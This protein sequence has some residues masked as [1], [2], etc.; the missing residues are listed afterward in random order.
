MKKTRHT[1][2]QIIEKLRQ[3][4]VALGKGHPTSQ[5]LT[6]HCAAQWQC[7]RRPSLVRVQ[8][9]HRSMVAPPT[10]GGTTI[11]QQR[12]PLGVMGRR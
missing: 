2:E 10:V 12:L 3:A 8:F 6:L 7:L 4:D 5:V 11:F 1:T 9:R